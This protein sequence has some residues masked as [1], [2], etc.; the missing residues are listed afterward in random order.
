MATIIWSDYLRYRASL[1]GFDLAR[2]EEILRYTQERYYDI[3]TGRMIAVGKDGN[4]LVA[5]PYEE[6]GDTL[7]PVMIHATT[8]QQIQLRLSNGRYRI[9]E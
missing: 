3:E 6:E 2:I 5:I 1:R 4:C 7:T 8:R 9:N